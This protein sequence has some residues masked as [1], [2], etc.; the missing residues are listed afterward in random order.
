MTTHPTAPAPNPSHT[1]TVP[2]RSLAHARTGDKGNRSS[3]CVICHDAA[4][5][6]VLV[7][8]VT[9]ERVAALL[10]HRRPTQVVRHL[11]PQLQAM[12]F[13]IDEV[14][15]GGVNDAL[16]LDG[17]GKALSALL[18]TLPIALP[19]GATLAATPSPNN[20]PGDA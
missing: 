18:L 1:P 14:L 4:S 17:H 5:W 7:Q 20:H 12:N 3:I 6:P 13:V 16:N 9:P 11:L 19:P 10:A 8:Q 15:E 2:L